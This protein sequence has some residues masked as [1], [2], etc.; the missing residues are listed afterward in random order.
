MI[1]KPQ[2]DASARSTRISPLWGNSALFDKHS[3]Q[4]RLLFAKRGDLCN[5][6]DLFSSKSFTKRQLLVTGHSSLGTFL[7]VCNLRAVFQLPADCAI[8]SRN[9]FV[10]RLNTV[11]D[12]HK[13]VVGD[14]GCYLYQ[15]RFS[16]LL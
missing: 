15:L 4:A 14:P 2:R 5:C 8:A 16:A 6:E 1:S 9:D 11:S 13:G 10:S 7:I 3:S 12:L